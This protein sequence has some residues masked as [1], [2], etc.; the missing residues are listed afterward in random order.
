MMQRAA[1]LMEDTGDRIGCMLNPESIV[2][3]RTAG[4]RARESES[5]PV[6]ASGLSDDPLLFTGG[7]STEVTL[8]LLFDVSIGGTSIDTEDVR[9]LTAPFFGLAENVADDDQIYGRPPLMRFVWGKYWNIPG[10]VV[11]VSERLEFFTETGAPRRSWLRMRFLRLAEPL[12]PPVPVPEIN[13]PPMAD[14][15][16][17]DIPPEQM[18]V[19]ETVGSG[20]EDHPGASGERPDLLADEYLGDPAAWR[21]V[22]ASEDIDDPLNIPPGTILRIPPASGIRGAS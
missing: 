1:F 9:D 14:T 7:G 6:T 19:H 21:W 18:I 22:V 8:D 10:I 2:I 12:R 5:G 17:I 4:V 16:A 15:D 20:S 3:Q 11:S 13:L